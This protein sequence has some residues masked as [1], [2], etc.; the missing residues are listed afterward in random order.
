MDALARAVQE[1]GRLISVEDAALV[2]ELELR[3]SEGR[4]HLTVLERKN[5]LPREELC[6]LRIRL[7]HLRRAS[8]RLKQLAE[9]YHR[10]VYGEL[11]ISPPSGSSNPSPEPPPNF[12]TEM[13]ER[14]S[15]RQDGCAEGN[16]S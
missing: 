2:S 9:A 10:H 11:S 13:T 1:Q 5:N 7:E 4:N 6:I 8:H 14:D 3:W 16:K 15:A 12:A